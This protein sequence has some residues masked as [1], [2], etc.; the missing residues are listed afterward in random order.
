M[1]AFPLMIVVL[2][3]CIVSGIPLAMLIATAFRQIGHW[4]DPTTETPPVFSWRQIM[5]ASTGL[6][7]LA[8][9]FLLASAASAA[10]HEGATQVALSMIFSGL[11]MYLGGH[12]LDRGIGSWFS[13]GYVDHDRLE[14]RA[15]ARHLDISP[16][17]VKLQRPLRPWYNR[18]MTISPLWIA[19]GA[20]VIV[21]CNA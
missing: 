21:L 13:R 12:V 18:M 7:V 4:L 15:L 11:A 16:S 1:A 5:V 17:E 2:P 6:L 8:A 10:P 14:R 19:M 20:I 3:A 9:T